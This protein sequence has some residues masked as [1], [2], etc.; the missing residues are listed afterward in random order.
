M[1]LEG[2]T[3]VNA[4]L[5]ELASGLSAGKHELADMS[6]SARALSESVKLLERSVGEL[7]AT[8]GVAM[9]AS[10]NMTSA[11]DLIGTHSSQL[12]TVMTDVTHIGESVSGVSATFKGIRSLSQKASEQME[13]LIR[14]VGQMGEAAAIVERSNLAAEGLAQG[15]TRVTEVMP[16]LAERTHALDAQL[17]SLVGSVTRSASSIEQDVK[18]STEAVSLFGERMVDVAQII[19]DRTR[20]EK[21]A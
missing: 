9:R 16:G 12:A 18:R 6:S 3:Q 11:L 5:A 10:A 7:G 17:A 2:T 20:Q 13:G 19:I 15:L 8:D 21:A 14:A 1:T 4:A